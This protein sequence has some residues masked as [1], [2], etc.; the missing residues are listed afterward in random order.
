MPYIYHIYTPYIC[1]KGETVW[2]SP[3]RDEGHN[4][5]TFE[6]VKYLEVILHKKLLWKKLVKV[7]MKP[8]LIAYKLCRRHGN[9]CCNVDI[10]YYH[11]A[12]FRMVNALSSFKPGRIVF[13]V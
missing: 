7:N 8:A 3:S 4:S 2:S 5:S 6:K 11:W 13:P 9:S 10:C 1:N 12:D